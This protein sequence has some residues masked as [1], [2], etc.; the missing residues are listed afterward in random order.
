VVREHLKDRRVQK[1]ER[2]LREALGSLIHEKNYD[3]IVVREILERAN[4]GRS[5]FYAHFSDKG[6]L[7]A[8]S[9]RQLL[10]EGPPRPLSASASRFGHTLGFSYPV[11]EHIDHFRHSSTAMMG[12]KTRAIVHHHLRRVLI[13]NVTEAIRA[14]TPIALPLPP[15]LLADYVVSTFILVLNWWVDSRS[16]LS[17]REVDD[18]FLSMVLPTLTATH[19]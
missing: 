10:S 15:V 18:I 11:F 3:S 17:P 14:A 1:T 16:T 5:A 4:V 8:N 2:L 12:R 7:L 13:E 9:I 19:G 6:A